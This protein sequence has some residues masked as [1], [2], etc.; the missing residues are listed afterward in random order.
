MPVSFLTA[1]QRES[2]GHFAGTPTADELGRYFHLD[3][4]DR[5]LIA[6]KRGAFNRLGFALQLTI[7]R[8]K[9]IRVWANGKFILTAPAGTVFRQNYPSNSRKILGKRRIKF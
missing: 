5:K 1:A 8:T 2:Y 9:N 6:Q 7:V 3:D 4:D